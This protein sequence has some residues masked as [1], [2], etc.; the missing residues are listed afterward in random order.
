MFSDEKINVYVLG[1]L[2]QN[3]KPR[4]VEEETSLGTNQKIKG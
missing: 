1:A 4:L 2:I 3:S